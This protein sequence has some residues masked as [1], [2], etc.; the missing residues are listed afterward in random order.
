MIIMAEL[1]FAVK[2]A[3][4][5]LMRC[6]QLLPNYF[7]FNLS[8]TV[9][10]VMPSLFIRCW[11]LSQTKF[12]KCSQ[13]RNNCGNSGYKEGGNIKLYHRG[14]CHG[15]TKFTHDYLTSMAKAI[16]KIFDE[17]EKKEKE[18]EKKKK[19]KKKSR[20]ESKTEIAK[21]YNTAMREESKY[22]E[23]VV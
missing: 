11:E 4:E 7:S 8:D 5:P 14:C 18:E 22:G 1:H 19:K 17:K 21:A 20:S 10:I 3:G 9:S 12:L 2:I 13:I 6:C 23:L 16:E 15:D